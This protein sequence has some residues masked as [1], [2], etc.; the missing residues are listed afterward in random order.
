MVTTAIHAA[1]WSSDPAPD[2]IA[3]VLSRTAEAGF[4][5]LALPL[6]NPPEMQISVLARHISES[7]VSCL[8]TAGLSPDRDIG[9]EDPDIRNRGTQHLVNVINAA[10][11]L[12]MTQ[13]N[14]VLYGALGH[15]SAPP[16]RD[17]V[18]RASDTLSDLADFAA[19]SG[20]TLCLEVVNRY[21][22][23]MLNTVAQA[24]DF[25]ALAERPNLKLHID[26]FHMAIEERDAPAAAADAMPRLG[27]FELDQSHR[28][29]LDEGSL[30]L[31][32]IAAP[33]RTRGYDGLV[34]VEAFAR[35]RLT[36]D[37]AN[38]LAI[39]RDHFNDADDLARQARSLI[40]RLFPPIPANQKMNQTHI[41]GD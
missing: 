6:R 3:R 5:C 28:G 21:E 10:C 9:A 25:L 2:N 14:G 24:M 40:E 11:D 27:Y 34:G 19:G 37:H 36:E 8:A 39:W 20:I 26:T 35:G 4:D 7:G 16:S 12:G 18:L 22:T 23:A 1:V 31:A 29:R 32:A 33:L 15:S 41:S 17:T 38:A 13:V 30:D